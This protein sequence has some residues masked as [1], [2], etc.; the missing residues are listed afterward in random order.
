VAG[1]D[2]QAFK[3]DI[4]VKVPGVVGFFGFGNMGQAIARGLLNADAIASDR[5]LA[6]DVDTAKR[7]IAADLGIRTADTAADLAGESDT[8]VLATKPQDIDVATQALHGKL[9]E[10]AR[11]V[12]IAA[13]IST[14][15]L[16]DRLGATTRVA[17]VMPNTPALVAAGA[18]VVSMSESCT[19]DDATVVRAIFEAVGIVEEAPESQM[20]AATALSG[21]GPAYY[22]AFVEACAEAAVELGMEPAQAGRLAAQ[23][24][25]GAGTL[26]HGSGESAATL[27]ERVTSKGGTTAAALDAFRANGFSDVV[28]DAMSAA[29]ARSKELGSG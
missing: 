28:R 6:F 17:R 10:S 15:Y 4:P 3:D 26:L 13:G 12:S 14:H 1:I 23:T 19:E 5:L 11:V 9:K 29:A 27:R 22:F 16:R 21:S 8:V 25:Y 20:D 24:L 18:S 2:G 7:G